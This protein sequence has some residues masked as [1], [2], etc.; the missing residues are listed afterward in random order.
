VR[1]F[2]SDLCGIEA[3]KFAQAEEKGARK[4]GAIH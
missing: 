2:A 4:V 3:F 1:R